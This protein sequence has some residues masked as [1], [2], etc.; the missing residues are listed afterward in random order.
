[1]NHFKNPKVK[2]DYSYLKETDLEGKTTLESIQ[3]VSPMLNEMNPLTY[4]IYLSMNEK[5][6]SE[7]EKTYYSYMIRAMMEYDR[8]TMEEVSKIMKT[9]DEYKLDDSEIEH[10][11]ENGVIKR[12]A[13]QDYHD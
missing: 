9:R 13:S 3:R 5:I 12:Y 1:M 8:Q 7:A 2:Y 6:L 4:S 11:D 10:V